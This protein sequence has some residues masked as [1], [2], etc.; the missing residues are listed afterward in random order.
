MEAIAFDLGYYDP[1]HLLRDFKDVSGVTPRTYV[2][3]LNAID[4]SFMHVSQYARS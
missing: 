4:K 1:S 2:D 3:Q